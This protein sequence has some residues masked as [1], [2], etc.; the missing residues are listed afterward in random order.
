MYRIIYTISRLL[1]KIKL[2]YKED[3][4]KK[5]A[6]IGKNFKVGIYSNCI[7]ESK[8]KENIFISDDVT[9]LGKLHC[10]GKGNIY[11]GNYSRIEFNTE[12]GAADSV[13]IGNCV[14]I[15]HDVYIYDNNNHPIENQKRRDLSISGF[16]KEL[17]SWYN[18]VIAPVTIEDN[19]WIGMSSI[20]LKGV[21]IGEGSI[22]AAGSV[23]TKNVP[24][25]TL[26]GGNPAKVL[27]GLRDC[28]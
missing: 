10:A 19:V 22:I 9:V 20:I 21:T 25:Y 14:I 7:N 18:S 17:N 28:R 4:F 12:I 24:P 11:I 26:V 5:N 15:S 13:Y 16:D 3:I 6:I 8:K 23:V 1:L 2:Y 27:K